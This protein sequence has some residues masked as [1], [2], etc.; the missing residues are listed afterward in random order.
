MRSCVFVAPRYQWAPTS[1]AARYFLLILSR[2]FF[3]KYA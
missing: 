1:A 3:V 2:S